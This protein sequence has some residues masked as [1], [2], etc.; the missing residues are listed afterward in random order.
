MAKW[1]VCLATIRPELAEKWLAGWKMLF[2]KY[3]VDVYIMQDIEKK[4]IKPRKGV[5]VFDHKDVRR[6][7]GSS[8]WVIPKK[9]GACRSF[10]MLQ[11]YRKK[12]DYYITLDDD[13]FPIEDTIAAYEQHFEPQHWPHYNYVDI[14][15]LMGYKHKLRGYPYRIRKPLDVAAQYGIWLK[16]ADYDAITSI[17]KPIEDEFQLHT[18]VQ[19]V[20]KYMAFTGCIMNVAIS[21]KYLP[22][23]YQLQMGERVGYDRFDDIWSALL[24]KKIADRFED[25]VV[26]NG[27]AKVLHDRASNAYNNLM[28]ELPAMAKNETVWE[29]LMDVKLT[30]D[31]PLEC[32]QE[33]AESNV[34]PD[35]KQAML[36]WTQI[37]K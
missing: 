6:D 19:A 37:I 18:V 32:Y 33:L 12:Y 28:K 9:T 36:S 15:D 23:M 29:E 4:T 10:A 25:V 5:Y 24:L 27:S 30:K 26:I 21:H 22:V 13:C 2:E 20:P 34:L 11:A 17:E 16:I 35:Q 7:L 31:T 1:A 3:G 14:A 8:D